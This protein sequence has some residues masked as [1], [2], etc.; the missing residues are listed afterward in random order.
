M[1][2]L[3]HLCWLRIIP[4][5]GPCSRLNV[6][7]HNSRINRSDCEAKSLKFGLGFELRW[8]SLEESKDVRW[9]RDGPWA[10]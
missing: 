1:H 6:L 5:S 3:S 10:G 7:L 2:V 9:D 4:L 8:A